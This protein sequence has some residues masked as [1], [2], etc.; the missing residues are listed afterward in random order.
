MQVGTCPA[1]APQF[2]VGSPGPDSGRPSNPFGSPVY[3]GDEGTSVRCRVTAS[4]DIFGE[5][6]ARPKDISF[7]VTGELDPETGTGT[8]II[9]MHAPGVAG[10]YTSPLEMPCSLTAIRT[11]QAGAVWARFVCSRM[12]DSSSP[13]SACSS[14]GE[15]LFE[16]CDK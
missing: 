3:S 6:E 10:Y 14:N 5:I 2:E 13:G 15:F 4:G 1:N 9:G 11:I 7:R 16:R 8:A 12:T